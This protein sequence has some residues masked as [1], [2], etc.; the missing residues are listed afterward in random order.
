MPWGLIIYGLPEALRLRDRLASPSSASASFSLA[1]GSLAG[2][3]DRDPPSSF[4]A[5][6]PPGD[7]ESRL[8]LRLPF[9][10]RLSASRSADDRTRSALDRESLS[11][12]S[13]SLP[14]RAG[15]R[16][17]GRLFT[18][19]SSGVRLRRRRRSRSSSRSRGD[20]DRSRPPGAPPRDRP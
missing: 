15:D 3:G 2:E 17:R 4:T 7:L 8:P 16:E 9:P 13:P 12:R 18:L 1:T 20:R 11:L 14:L 6:P 10:S 5:S 19:S